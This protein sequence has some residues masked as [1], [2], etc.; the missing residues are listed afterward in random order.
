MRMSLA[1]AVVGLGVAAVVSTSAMAE[2]ASRRHMEQSYNQS[3]RKGGPIEQPVQQQSQATVVQ[4]QVAAAPLALYDQFP[5]QGTDQ[6]D[7]NMGVNDWHNGEQGWQVSTYLGPG[8][9]VTGDLQAGK[10]EPQQVSPAYRR[11]P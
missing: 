3:L 5:M 9:P 7:G 10:L 11:G 1:W 4:Q 8:L 2:S 6:P